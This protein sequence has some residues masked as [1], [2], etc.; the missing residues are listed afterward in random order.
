MSSSRSPASR[1]EH[2][3]TQLELVRS[4]RAALEQLEDELV[5]KRRRVRSIL[6]GASKA[7]G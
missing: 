4:R 5:V 7:A 6:D 2:I 3:E 1:F